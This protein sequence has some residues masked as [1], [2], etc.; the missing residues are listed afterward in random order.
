[1]KFIPIILL[2]IAPCIPSTASAYTGGDSLITSVLR[3]ERAV[4]ETRNDTTKALLLLEKA[5]LYKQVAN[6]EETLITLNRIDPLVLTDTVRAHFFYT[7]AYSH[8]LLQ[9]YREALFELW[10][11]PTGM[12]ATKDYELLL[13]MTL[14]ENERWDDFNLEYTRQVEKSKQPVL[15]ENTILQA[16]IF[17]DPNYYAKQAKYFPGLGLM[18]SGYY[19]RGFTSLG[20]QLCFVGFAVYNFSAAYY[21]TG[22]LSGLFPAR[23]F[24]LGSRLLTQS[25][26]EQR[27]QQAI[28]ACKV[29]GYALL[30]TLP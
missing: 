3:L 6:Y 19:G 12:L 8:F 23:K 24:Y 17:L 26:V 2:L 15:P 28:A 1:M 29:K 9:R 22:V 13:L 5:A 14:L 20:L 10:N 30:A 4:M 27:N 7:K 21:A 11:V 25:M 16:P 18:K